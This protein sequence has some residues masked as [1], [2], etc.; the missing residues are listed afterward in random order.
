MGKNVNYLVVFFCLISAKSVSAAQNETR[1]LEYFLHQLRT[2]EHLPVLE[3]SHTAMASTYDRQGDNRDDNDFKNIIGR[4]NILLDVNGP[5]CIHRIFTGVVGKEIAGTNIQ[6]FL[7]DSPNAVFD[8]PVYQVLRLQKR[9]YTLSI[10]VS[11]NLSGD[12][13]SD[14]ICQTLSCSACQRPE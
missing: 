10:G 12:F 4:R 2:V 7:D 5:G 14:T 11:Q 6:I 9:A 8:M 3:N 13:V 1:N